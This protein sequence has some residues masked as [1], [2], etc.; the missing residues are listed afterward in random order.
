[1]R[2]K[3]RFT[4]LAAALATAACA[5]HKLPPEVLD[6]AGQTK[7]G[8]EFYIE[9]APDGTVLGADAIV[10]LDAVPPALRAAADSA[11]PGGRQVGAEREFGDGRLVWEVVKE[12]DGRLFEIL[13]DADGT[14]VGGEE[15]L[16][17]AQWP[18]N[19]V[20]AAQGEVP[21]GRIEA[22]EKVWGPEAHFGEA[23]HV[24]VAKDGD[25]LRVGVTADGRVVRTVRRIPGQVRI[26][27]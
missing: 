21:G 16:A 13:L 25:S 2:T 11:F 20:A 24:K 27:R 26:H 4:V 6:L 5:T 12:I 15:A 19:V 7:P 23:Y 17:Q 1:M 22:V 18:A 9:F 10:E 3:I 14:V 8:G